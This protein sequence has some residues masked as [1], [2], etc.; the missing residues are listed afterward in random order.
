ML[1]P[2]RKN[3]LALFLRLSVM[4]KVG[5]ILPAGNVVFRSFWVGRNPL[6]TASCMVCPLSPIL[7]VIAESLEG[8]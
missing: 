8:R 7:F 3:T 2:V 6:Q 1:E 5:R 4:S